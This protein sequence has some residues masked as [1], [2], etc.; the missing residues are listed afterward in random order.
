LAHSPKGSTRGL[1][2]RIGATCAELTR[3]GV[4]VEQH[5]DG[6]TVHPCDKMRPASVRTYNDH[7]M[8]MA[9]SL[10][11]LRVPGVIIE[12]PGCVSKSF[13]AFFDVLDS[14]R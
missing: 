4:I 14:L 10:I 1:A 11:G 7:R 6:L 13:P 5:P 9:F 3:L 8:A 2:D 12:D